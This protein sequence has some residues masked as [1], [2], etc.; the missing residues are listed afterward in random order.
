MNKNAKLWTGM[1]LGLVLLLSGCA[2]SVIKA[3][4]GKQ[5]SLDK[6]ATVT[7]E[8]A[9]RVLAVDGNPEYRLYSGGG[10]YYQ[11]CAISLLPGK[12]SI[13]YQYYF[14]SNVMTTYTPSVTQSVD[15]KA[16]EIYRIRY[17]FEGRK[18]VP[19]I[20]KLQGEKYQKQ[21][22]DLKIRLKNKE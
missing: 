3:Y 17:V 13:R 19:W 2:S 9:I 1:L 14:S 11:D 8:S 5:L 4:P 15:A 22:E 10:L 16:G 6:V 12:H 7:C 20:E 21:R 18:W